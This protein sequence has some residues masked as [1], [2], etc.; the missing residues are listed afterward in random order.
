MPA[1]V[2]L[3]PRRHAPPPGWLR[4]LDGRI[5]MLMLI[6]ACFVTQYI[7]DIWLPLWLALLACLFTVR[8]MRTGR[9][10]ALARGAFWFTLFWLVMK[11][12][13]DLMGGKEPMEALLGGLPL[14]GRL[15]ALSII[16]MAFIGL[17]S[18]IETGRAFAW[19]IKPLAGKWAWKPA[20]VIALTA[21]F[22]PITL[23]LA[24]DVAGSIRSRGLIMP[25]RKK[26]LLII[27]T[28]LRILEHTAAELA[29]GLVSRRVG[30]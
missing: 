27:G 14:A 17:S 15:A 25:W 19:F 16:G 24:G 4:R 3:P 29:V 7:A 9:V 22:L 1:N 8:E 18:P 10:L 26:V 28:A 20:L 11:V 12:G 23:R 21:W 6:A 13:S 2:S 30:D 5:K